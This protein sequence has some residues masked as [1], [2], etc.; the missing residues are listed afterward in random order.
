MLKDLSV[1]AVV[2]AFLQAACLLFAP[3]PMKAELVWW[4]PWAT[5]AVTQGQ[6]VINPHESRWFWVVVWATPGIWALLCLSALLGLDWGKA[7]RNRPAVAWYSHS[8]WW[9]NEKIGAHV[10][11]DWQ[12]LQKTL[13]RFVQQELQHLL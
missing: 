7:M 2:T 11:V 8:I 10:H 3:A 12:H 6:R 1:P 13:S 5:P 9:R 4:P